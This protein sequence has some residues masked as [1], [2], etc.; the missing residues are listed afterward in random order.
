MRALVA[1]LILAL[2]AAPKMDIQKTML[3]CPGRPMPVP[4]FQKG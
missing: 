4:I 1:P 2:I 3:R